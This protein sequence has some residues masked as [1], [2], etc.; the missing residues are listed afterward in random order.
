MKKAQGI[1]ENPDGGDDGNDSE[2]S[3]YSKL[4]DWLKANVLKKYG[5]ESEQYWALINEILNPEF[6]DYV[7]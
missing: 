6:R 5:E 1:E 2:I 3:K 4:S 7:D